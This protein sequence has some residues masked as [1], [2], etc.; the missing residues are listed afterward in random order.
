MKL[1]SLLCVL[2]MCLSL[3]GHCPC[4]GSKPCDPSQ[5][6]GPCSKSTVVQPQ[7]MAPQKIFLSPQ[8]QALVPG[9]KKKQALFQK[10]LTAQVRKIEHKQV[11]RAQIFAQA[12][13]RIEQKNNPKIQSTQPSPTVMPSILS[14]PV[15]PTPAVIPSANTHATPA[16]VAQKLDDDRT[17]LEWPLLKAISAA[18]TPLIAAYPTEKL[19]PQDP[20]KCSLDEQLEQMHTVATFLTKL[21]IKL[22]TLSP[23]AR[24]F[25]KTAS[26]A[27]Q[28]MARILAK[29]LLSL[30]SLFESQLEAYKKVKPQPAMIKELKKLITSCAKEVDMLCKEL[31]NV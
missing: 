8:A 21:K 7:P 22:E 17:E 24:D 18:L 26:F 5:P 2:G 1:T 27:G 20:T 13:A 25:I 30:Q 11:V 19:I 6:C 29:N 15:A 16:T 9:I 4:N 23:E 3:Q 14:S 31:L 12:V 10:L 28:P